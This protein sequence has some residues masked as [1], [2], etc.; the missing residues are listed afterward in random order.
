MRK[1][2]EVL[3]LRFELNLDQRQIARSCSI[4]VST[5]H[6]Y[7]KRAEAAAVGWPLPTDWSDARLQTALFPPTTTT[8]RHCK[9]SLDCEQIRRV[10][11]DPDPAIADLARRA[12]LGDEDAYLVLEDALRERAR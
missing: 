4:S 7:L 8:M 2:K 3:R 6:E 5:V 12:Q 11:A 9:D 10:R 1:L